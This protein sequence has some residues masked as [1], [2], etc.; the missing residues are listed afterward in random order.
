MRHCKS[1]AFKRKAWCR[2][3]E[4]LRDRVPIVGCSEK[5]VRECCETGVFGYSSEIG[6][7]VADSD[8]FFQKWQETFGND[9]V[10]A[11]GLLGDL[12]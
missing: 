11:K 9:K 1:C 10:H 4:D 5:F 7:Y 6:I 3:W 12:T 8:T 2:F